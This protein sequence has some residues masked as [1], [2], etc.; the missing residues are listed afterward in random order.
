MIR[1]VEVDP[2]DRARIVA[3]WYDGE[4]TPRTV[5]VSPCPHCGSEATLRRAWYGTRSF[6][7]Y[8]YFVS[9]DDRDNCGAGQLTSAT[10]EDALRKWNRRESF[11]DRLGGEE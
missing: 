8:T 3:I 2:R 1:D 10:I 11:H 5:Y 4:P 6:S 9:C 7:E